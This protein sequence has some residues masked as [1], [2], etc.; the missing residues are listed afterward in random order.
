MII[1]STQSNRAK[2]TVMDM[3]AGFKLTVRHSNSSFPT[4]SLTTEK[5]SGNVSNVI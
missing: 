4:E 2:A 1:G 3:K 5:R